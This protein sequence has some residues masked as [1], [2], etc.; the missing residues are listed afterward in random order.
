MR[1]FFLTYAL[2]ALLVV[3]IFGLR[4]QKFTKPPV[5]IFPD[6]DEQDKLTRPEAG[7]IL[8]GRPRRPPSGRADPAAR[9]QSGRRDEHRRHPRI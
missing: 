4:G 3:G 7:S 1:Y 5:R 2:I 6:M 8:R 9:I